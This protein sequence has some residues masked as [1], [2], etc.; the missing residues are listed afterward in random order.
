MRIIDSPSP[1]HNPR[2]CGVDM[3]ILHYTGMRSADDALARLCAPDSKVSAHYLIAENGDVFG[4]VPEELRAWHAGISRWRGREDLNSASVGIELVNPG[5]AFGYRAFPEPQ[6]A[7]LEALAGGIV[8]RH[9]IPARNVVGHSDVAPSRKDDP[10][11]LFDWARLARA[12]IGLWPTHRPV[13]GELGLALGPGAAG[14]PVAE[15]QAALAAIG[16]DIQASGAFDVA[17]ESVV[18]AFQ[19]RYRP[20]RID[21][22]ADPETVQLVYAVRAL[23]G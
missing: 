4:L 3:L 9:P 6:M 1:N 19:R 13:G 7:A 18:R 12:G 11:E 23:A 14:P 15:V 10:G 17:T 2:G 5:H 20:R 22:R 8:A 21:G 16:Y